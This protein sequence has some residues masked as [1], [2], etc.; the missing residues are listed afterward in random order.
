MTHVSG[1]FQ[2]T[3]CYW[4]SHFSD[5]S[6]IHITC[7]PGHLPDGSTH[8]GVLKHSGLRMVIFLTLYMASNRICRPL[9]AI[10]RTRRVWPPLYLLCKGHLKLKPDSRNGETH[11]ASSLEV[12][13]LGTLLILPLGQ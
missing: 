8:P 13:A 7:V 12:V 9:R 10:C 3:H 2:C 6:F 11:I 1:T 5:A 4:T